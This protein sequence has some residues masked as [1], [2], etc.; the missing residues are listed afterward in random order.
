MKSPK[1]LNI[2]WQE[3]ENENKDEVFATT[4]G[5]KDVVIYRDP[6][7]AYW[8]IK[9]GSGGELPA[10]LDQAFTQRNYAETAIKTYLASK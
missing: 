5:G 9:F 10:L 1:K 3:E 6:V 7:Y 2:V 8:R 4:E